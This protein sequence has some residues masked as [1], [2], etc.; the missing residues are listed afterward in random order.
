MATL[1]SQTLSD[2]PKRRH[3]RE[4]IAKEPLP[5]R[6]LGMRLQNILPPV[7]NFLMGLDSG[8]NIPGAQ[9]RPDTTQAPVVTPP[10]VSQVQAPVGPGRFP[11]TGVPL[12]PIAPPNTGQVLMG[13]GSLG[14][15]SFGPSIDGV[16]QALSGGVPG[17]Q[18]GQQGA[19]P[20]S[21]T[22]GTK[23]GVDASRAKVV[24]ARLN[25]ALANPTIQLALAQFGQAFTARDQN[26]F[27]YM[28]G[29]AAANQAKGQLQGQY[30]E[31]LLGGGDPSKVPP[32]LTP[33]MAAEAMGIAQTQQQ[34]ELGRDRLEADTKIR[35]DYNQIQKDLIGMR[36]KELNA[37]LNEVEGLDS[38]MAKRVGAEVGLQFLNLARE[39][40]PD[41][42]RQYNAFMQLMTAEDGSFNYNAVRDMLYSFN[43]DNPERA[44]ELTSQ[45][46][47]MLAE[48]TI[49]AQR[50]IDPFEYTYLRAAGT[51]EQ[52]G[53]SREN[54]EFQSEQANQ[55]TEP[56]PEYNKSQMAQA[57]DGEI[58]YGTFQGRGRVLVRKQ[59][60]QF[61]PVSE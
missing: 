3:K 22:P 24:G 29:E 26:S 6:R 4:D 41:Q 27:G 20:T 18:V 39:S 23:P 52:A 16:S 33:D 56:P 13:E 50:D 11:A 14:Q 43:E 58:F 19:T 34:I 44:R 49:A 31:H 7:H 48:Y 55:A 46:N 9:A 60:D 2:P 51:A 47:R 59:G 42:Y 15:P 54:E 25:E 37:K 8:S 57:R 53:T 32:G 1:L 12:N 35:E 40:M 38:D 28:L 10:P 36:E 30:I 61:I 5:H 17:V 45:F 21:V